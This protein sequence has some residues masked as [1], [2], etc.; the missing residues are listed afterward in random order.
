MLQFPVIEGIWKLG[1]FL[2]IFGEEIMHA[3]EMPWQRQQYWN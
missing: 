3:M 1:Q 2:C